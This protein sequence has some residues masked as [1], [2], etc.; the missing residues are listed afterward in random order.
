M[1]VKT[2]R[3]IVAIANIASIECAEVEQLK[4]FVR[5]YDGQVLI[6]TDIHALELVMQTCP[7]MLEGK[8]FRAPKRAWLVHNLI[9]HPLM[10]I[11]A[12]MGF[13]KAAFRIHDATVP[14]GMKRKS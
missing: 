11:L 14:Q 1:F 2:D 7:S 3:D 5:T 8:A 13:Y 12:L 4:V 6:A 9:A 10:Q